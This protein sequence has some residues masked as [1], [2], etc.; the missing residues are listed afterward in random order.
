M[1]AVIWYLSTNN[2]SYPKTIYQRR[3]NND[4]SNTSNIHINVAF[5]FAW[6]DSMV[7]GLLRSKAT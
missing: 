2:Q 4:R 5:S 6:C 1:L 3:L 7:F